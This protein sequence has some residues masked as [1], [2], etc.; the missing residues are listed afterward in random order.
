MQSGSGRGWMQ[1]TGGDKGFR[2]QVPSFR[3][4]DE[5]PMTNNEYRSIEKNLDIGNSTLDIRG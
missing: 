2:Y 3:K 4:K 1:S 5:Y